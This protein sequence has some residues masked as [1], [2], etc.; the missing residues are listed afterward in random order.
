MAESL[1][2]VGTLMDCVFTIKRID[3][4]FVDLAHF[5]NVPRCLMCLKAVVFVPY[6]G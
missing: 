6:L 3:V 5:L 1:E 2:L 4:F